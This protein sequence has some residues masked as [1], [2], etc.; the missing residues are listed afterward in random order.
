M[1]IATKL[2]EK[3]ET[4]KIDGSAQEVEKFMIT[5]T[6]SGKEEVKCSLDVKK[7]WEDMMPNK[8]TDSLYDSIMGNGKLMTSNT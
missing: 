5:S 2:I 8:S 7:I 1:V 3:M 6:T 4:K